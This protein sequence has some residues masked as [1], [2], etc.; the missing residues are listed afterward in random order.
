VHLQQNLCTENRPQQQSR[1]EF[2]PTRSLA[3]KLLRVV[4]CCSAE[5]LSGVQEK[6]KKNL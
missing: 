1:I 3:R 2:A 6:K 4:L 5:L